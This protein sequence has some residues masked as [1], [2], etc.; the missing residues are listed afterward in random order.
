MRKHKL[1]VNLLYILNYYFRRTNNFKI[2]N[3]FVYRWHIS[4]R[5]VYHLEQM[6]EQYYICNNLSTAVIAFIY[7]NLG[8]K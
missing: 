7:S 4:S 3:L 8:R 1:G 5:I 6:M 2:R